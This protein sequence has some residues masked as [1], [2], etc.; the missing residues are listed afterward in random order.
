MLPSKAHVL[1]AVLGILVAV[2]ATASRLQPAWG[3][4]FRVDNKVFTG[5][6]AEPESQGITLFHHGVAYDFLDNPPEVVVLDPAAAR[7]ILLDVGRR[8][9]AEVGIKEV[10]LLNDFQQVWA[11]RQ[12]SAVLQF[13]GN[14]KL[15]ESFNK[16]A[17]G[18]TMSSPWAIY[19]IELAPAGK[20][21]VEQYRVFCDCYARLNAVL[22]PK[23]RPPFVRLAVDEAI[24]RHGAI[25][26]QIE[27]TLVAHKGETVHRSVI[28]SRHKL[29]QPLEKADLD[30]IAATQRD[31]KAFKPASFEEYRKRD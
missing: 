30:R 27:L 11:T 24:F 1:T 23:S 15:D 25:P 16:K 17:S 4:D 8:M 3:E 5:N 14:P 12:P 20:S 22:A 18:L 29:V 19:K 9:V 31:I 7:F 2:A 6:A 26:R 10:S 28:R 13:F 21:V